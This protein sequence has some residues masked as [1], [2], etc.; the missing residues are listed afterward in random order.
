MQCLIDYPKIIFPYS[1]KI[2]Q[3]ESLVNLANRPW[4]SKLKLSKLV[5]TIN[6]LLADLLIRKMF[7]TSQFTK[8]PP[9]QLSCYMVHGTQWC[10]NMYWKCWLLQM[11]ISLTMIN[12]LQKHLSREWLSSFSVIPFP[13][14][15]RYVHSSHGI[16]HL[17]LHD[18]W[19]S[20]RSCLPSS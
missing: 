2:W 18:R 5:L 1:G 8:L 7:E 6:N 16:Y 11:F 12:A 15:I 4:F 14:I 9:S 3:G 17:W 19:Y 20:T 10:K 13:G